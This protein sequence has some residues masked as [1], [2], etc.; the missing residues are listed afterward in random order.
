MAHAVR[1]GDSGAR[2]QALD[3]L[4]RLHDEVERLA[5]RLADRHASRLQCR[6]GCDGCCRDDLS[7]FT[8]E[9][10]R[11]RKNHED[12]LERGEPAAEGRCALLDSGGSCRV[13]QDRP[14][15]CRTQGLPLRWIDDE[16]IA[17]IVEY[18]DICPLNEA[19]GPPLE[20]LAADECWTVGPSERELAA[21]Q[22]AF[23]G[24]TRRIRLRDL[25]AGPR[26]DVE[27]TT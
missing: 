9:A 5:G 8:V 3:R 16:D 7:V 1:G 25:F 4:R 23:A 26:G 27:P 24:D 2:R 15:V 13:Y 14:Y 10:E 22:R 6:R 11:I 12:L 21:I 20:S 17:A 18:R 19:G